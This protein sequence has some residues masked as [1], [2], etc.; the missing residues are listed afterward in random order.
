MAAMM[1]SSEGFD[2]GINI[3]FATALDLESRRRRYNQNLWVLTSGR[4]IANDMQQ[5]RIKTEQ[6]CDR[7]RIERQ[8][9]TAMPGTFAVMY[10]MYAHTG[11]QTT[12]P[13]WIC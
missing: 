8:G 6:G 10:D 2:H 3:K 12:N 5:I 11:T 9:E 1:E 13:H 7:L 4:H